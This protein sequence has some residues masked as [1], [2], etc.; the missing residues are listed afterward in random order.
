MALRQSADKLY[1]DGPEDIRRL[2]DSLARNH[3][4]AI[5][6]FA[7]A[8]CPCGALDFGITVDESR[9][10]TSPDCEECRNVLVTETVLRSVL[11]W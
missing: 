11:A 1:G 9:C 6:H 8:R 5:T 7:D 3:G 2:L 4:G 10:C